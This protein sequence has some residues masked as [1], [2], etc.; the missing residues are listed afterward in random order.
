MH[1]RKLLI[2]FLFVLVA[3]AKIQSSFKSV[4]RPFV[5]IIVV[6]PFKIPCLKLLLRIPCPALIVGKFR[7]DHLTLCQNLPLTFLLCVW[8]ISSHFVICCILHNNCK[9]I[10]YFYYI[11]SLTRIE[12]NKCLWLTTSTKRAW[13]PSNLDVCQMHCRR[14]NPVTKLGQRQ[15]TRI[16]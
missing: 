15:C 5:V 10:S 2:K 12:L 4:F 7:Q 14:C 6:G 9:L 3:N 16:M 8:E 1:N 11:S 13:K